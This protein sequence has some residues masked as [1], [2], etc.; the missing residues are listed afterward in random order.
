MPFEK[1]PINTIEGEIYNQA[2]E[3]C[4]FTKTQETFTEQ[5]WF[6]CHTCK[7]VENK[8]VCIH[9]AKMCHSDHEISYSKYSPFFCDC[10]AKGDAYCN[11]LS[12]KF[13]EKFIAKK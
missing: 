5:H 3:M 4:T 6:Y 7:M 8:G 13:V 11:A 10:G 2:I 9:C 12:E 1:Q